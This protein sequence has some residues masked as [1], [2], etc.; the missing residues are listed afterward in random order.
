M[1][2]G[3]RGNIMSPIKLYKISAIA[4]LAV[5]TAGAF[6]PA[7]ARGQWAQNHPRRAQVNDRLMLQN[8][9]INQEFREGEINRRQAALLHQQDRQIRLEERAMARQNG[10]YITQQERRQLNRQENAVSRQIGR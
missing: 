2:A 7:W 8:H 1:V 10:G 3:Y 5:I 6:S 9:R 4:T